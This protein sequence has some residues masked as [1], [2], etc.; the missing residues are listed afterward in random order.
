MT[1]TI[2]ANEP[3]SK[4]IHPFFSAPKVAAPILKGDNAVTPPTPDPSCSPA[5]ERS[6]IDDNI[7]DDGLL[8]PERKRRRTSPPMSDISLPTTAPRTRQPKRASG[9]ASIAAHFGQKD[10]QKEVTSSDQVNTLKPTPQSS[11]PNPTQEPPNA[12]RDAAI[13]EQSGREPQSTEPQQPKRVLKLNPKTGTI[14]SPPRPK[15]STTQPTSTGSKRGRKPKKHLVTIPY[16][17]DADARKR[18]GEHVNQIL[19]GTCTFILTKSTTT[20]SS[21]KALPIGQASTKS[22]A[23]KPS[24]PVTKAATPIKPNHPFFQPKSKPTPATGGA[25]QEGSKQPK[26]FSPRRQSIFTSTPCSPRRPKITSLGFKG[27]TMSSKNGLLRTPGAQHPAW[28]WN[29]M[30]HVRDNIALDHG[31]GSNNIS[32]AVEK[33]ERKAKR[34][35]IQLSL[36]ESILRKTL[37][38]LD[39]DQLA[40]AVKNL[41]SKD[42]TPISPVVRLPEKHFESGQILQQRVRQELRTLRIEGAASKTHAAILQVYK[43]ISTTLSAFDRATCESAAWTQKYAPAS[44]QCI[45]QSG[46]EAELLR[47]WLQALKVQAVDTGASDLSKLRAAA[48]PQKKRRRKQLDD[49]VVSSEDEAD[50][51]DEISET[52][53]DWMTSGSRGAA[54]KT[55]L[56][57]RDTQ[58]G[59]K[60]STRLTNAVLL[61]GPHG[62]GK[63]TTVYAIAKELDFEVFE[64]HAGA[65]RNGKDI[66][67]K[68][69][70]MTQNHLVSHQQKDGAQSHLVDE[71]ETE[72][73]LQAGKQGMMTSFFKP[74][75]PAP[76]KEAKKSSPTVSSQ[77][78]SVQEN[79]KASR[80]QK[81][82]L[83]LLEEVDILYE[84]DKQF[85]AT[86]VSMI[87]QSK[88][89]FIMTCNDETVVPLQILKLHGIFRFSV[90]PTDLAVDLLLSISANEGHALRRDA[91]EAL[92]ESRGHDLRA[93]ITELNYWC[94]TGVGNVRGGVDWFLPRW[95]KGRDIDA[96]GN[97]I[98]VVS[99]DTYRAGMGWLNRDSVAAKPISQPVVEELQR[100]AWDYWGLD[101]LDPFDS[102]DLTCWAKEAT[103]H[104]NTNVARLALMES[105]DT[106][107]ELMSDADAFGSFLPLDSSY[108]PLDA[109][110][111]PMH[112]KM[113]DD[114]TIG[115]QVVEA[116]YASSY[117]SI[118]LDVC[119][120]LRYLAQ[121]WLQNA[122]PVPNQQCPMDS[123][124]E[125]QVTH[126]IRHHVKH[127][128]EGDVPITRVDYSL[129]FDPIAASDKMMAS[130]YLDPSIF[131]RTMSAVSL[132][133]APYVRS[134]VAYDQ[135]LQ[136]ERRARSS[137]LSEGGKP[138][139]K[140]VRT[141]RAA[142]SALE[143]GSRAST[144]REK[145]FSAEI[146]PYLVL[147]TGGNGWDELIHCVDMMTM[148]ADADA[149]KED[150][151]DIDGDGDSEMM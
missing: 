85:W 57:S 115:R 27:P 74:K 29:G 133:V 112:S 83:I 25:Q 47:D 65:R 134:I 120:S 111:P 71:D 8:E 102:E 62:C 40:D 52:E 116:S 141:T 136:N 146:N 70:N 51:M 119:S 59:G 46:R 98:R 95:P 140:R 145:Y 7:D 64:I 5:S 69:G 60:S 33:A 36:D 63:T 132:D 82:S 42:F 124:T 21:G 93:S 13:G 76:K 151:G 118:G 110:A 86:V 23:T 30:V 150:G 117:H 45:L 54:Q 100:E 34:Q 123:F 94:Q 15:P 19:R 35:E 138:D 6:N 17:V 43:S 92:Y 39:I 103:N 107:A 129:A 137:L 105:V 78:V 104:A 97:I 114:F 73:D 41:C 50:D 26:M 18:I 12:G 20:P 22:D 44:A 122:Q 128:T 61:S 143:G 1:E 2:D 3:Q 142:Y 4:K 149:P 28:P 101:I 125:E 147:R 99:Q 75:A 9:S 135:R 80:D 38:E 31:P 37:N 49:F 67:E 68:V 11:V 130:G 91:V 48:A 72:R 79:K 53:S 84:E 16:G 131:D 55:V 32:M 77:K 96:D 14:G 121:S 144:R 88:R 108:C 81:Q 127:A 139:K 10:V 126:G 109:T 24:I 56:R 89:P 87:A 90:P 58:R 66:L 113:L 148:A 106:F